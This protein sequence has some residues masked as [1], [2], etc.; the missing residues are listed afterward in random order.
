VTGGSGSY[1]VQG[2]TIIH[3]LTARPDGTQGA[4]F[5]AYATFCAQ[6][7]SLQLTGKDGAYLFNQPSLRTLD[8]GSIPAVSCTDMMQGPNEQGVDC[9]LVCGK[10]CP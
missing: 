5:P 1:Y 8:L 6:N 4:D 10:P 9:G 3:A 2:N 7:G